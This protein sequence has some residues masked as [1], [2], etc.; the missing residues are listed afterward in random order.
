MNQLDFASAKRASRVSARKCPFAERVLSLA[1]PD[2]IQREKAMAIISFRFLQP[3]A[4]AVRAATAAANAA[5]SA[6]TR[7]QLVFPVFSSTP[8]AV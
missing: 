4:D 5:A 2:P 6:V 8:L 7:H 1:E 3:I